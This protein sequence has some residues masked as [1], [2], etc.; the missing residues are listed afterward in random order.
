M[1]EPR[2]ESQEQMFQREEKSIDCKRTA[3][4]VLAYF[5]M[6]FSICAFFSPITTLLGYVPLLGGFLSNVVGLAIF[7]AALIVCI[8]LFLLAVAICWVIVHPKVGLVLLAVA[9][10]ATGIVL[11]IIFTN[12]SNTASQPATTHF[13]V[14]LRTY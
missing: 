13:G 7:L 11:A 2:I 3:L 1:I 8:P 5:I 6:V 12:K 4:R 14:S 9:L 10:L